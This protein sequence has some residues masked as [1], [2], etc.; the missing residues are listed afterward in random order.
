M[1][2]ASGDGGYVQAGGG[3]LPQARCPLQDAQRRHPAAGRPVQRRGAI[4]LPEGAE[5]GQS[6]EGAQGLAGS[7]DRLADGLKRLLR[8]LLAQRPVLLEDGVAPGQHVRK[9][10]QRRKT[11][12]HASSSM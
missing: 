1:L 5:G 12:M 9:L 11:R 8:L 3:P 7:V 2:S 6:V 10:L 4:R